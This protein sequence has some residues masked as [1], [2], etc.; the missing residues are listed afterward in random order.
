MRD[1][2]VE[3]RLDLTQIRIERAAEIRKRAIVERSEL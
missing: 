1:G 3:R 2:D